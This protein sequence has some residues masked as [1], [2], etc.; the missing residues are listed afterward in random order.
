MNHIRISIISI[1][2]ILLLSGILTAQSKPYSLNFKPYFGINSGKTE[3]I[4]KLKDT[5]GNFVKSQLEFPLDQTMF[6]GDVEL[7]LLPGTQKEWAFKFGYY[8]NISDPTGKM[9][10]H[11]WT[12]LR[13]GSVEKFSYT[14]SDVEGKNSILVINSV[15][16]VGLLEK[17]TFRDI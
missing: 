15:T 4:M 8:T 9:F 5:Q 6:G 14:E 1:I 3:Y 2:I 17:S 13:T 12:N 10:D 16:Y 11:D 7:K